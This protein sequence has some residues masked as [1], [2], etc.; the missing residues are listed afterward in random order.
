MA[1]DRGRAF[2]TPKAANP[3]SGNDSDQPTKAPVQAHSL[4]TGERYRLPAIH[5]GTVRHKHGGSSPQL[6]AKAKQRVAEDKV[7]AMLARQGIE[8]ANPLD[9]LLTQLTRTAFAAGAYAEMVSELQALYGPNHLGDG[10][11]HVL[12]CTPRTRGGAKR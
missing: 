7:G 11:P 5:G 10:A 1:A 2:P 6:K 4:R 3:S 12:S 8:A 9:V